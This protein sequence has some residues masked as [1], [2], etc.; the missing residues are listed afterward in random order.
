MEQVGFY[1]SS[2]SW[3]G[4]EMNFIKCAIWVSKRDY[5]VKIYCVK[6]SPIAKKLVDSDIKVT[7]VPRNKKY[8]DIK[9]AYRI[10]KL[11]KKDN[12]KALWLRDN[13]DLSTI[14]LAKTLSGNKFKIIYHQAMQIGVPKK[15]FF[16]NLRFS[17][18]DAWISL[19][20][21]LATQV[22]SHTNF[23]HKKIHVIPLAVDMKPTT[24]ELTKLEARDKFKLP[25]NKFVIGILGRISHH[26]GQLFLVKQLAKLRD[27]NLDIELLIV[28]EPTRNENDGY[29]ELL[30]NTVK[31]LNLTKH[32]HFHSFISEP[33]IFYNAIDLFIMASEGETFGTVTIEAMKSG[34][35]VLGTNSAGTPEIL[36]NGNLGFLYEANNG[37]DFCEQIDWIFNNPIEVNRKTTS[38]KI[39]ADHK[40]SKEVVSSQIEQVFETLE[41]TKCK[42]S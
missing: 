39:I 7:Y 18:I 37:S 11:I 42:Q 40:Y 28:G 20:N 8:Y 2:I 14:G 38:A 12:I 21:N 9:N 30:T 16:H 24:E 34:V 4:L 35:P 31:D 6:D 13:R 26:K 15:D 36:E 22:K 27:Q 5:R 25:S 3:G 23:D 33:Q 19:L 41:L 17:K 1:C 29:F 10:S 32:V